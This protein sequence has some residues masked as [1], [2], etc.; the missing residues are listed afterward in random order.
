MW[1]KMP[2]NVESPLEL[3]ALLLR[4]EKESLNIAISFKLAPEDTISYLITGR[5]YKECE[6]GILPNAINIQIWG[7]ES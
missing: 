3:Y 4:L 6:P 2:D 5:N 7:L 1:K